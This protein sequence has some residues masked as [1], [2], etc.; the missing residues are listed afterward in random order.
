[1]QSRVWSPHLFS[2]HLR[3]VYKMD[4]EREEEREGCECLKYTR[5]NKRKKKRETRSPQRAIFLFFAAIAIE[6]PA[7]AIPE[8]PFLVHG[9]SLPYRVRG[10]MI[11]K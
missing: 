7:H 4:K 9:M 6:M 10:G 2:K 1:M 5:V 11:L 3:V 8:F